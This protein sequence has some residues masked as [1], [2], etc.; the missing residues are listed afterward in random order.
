M[1]FGVVATIQC[2]QSVS[3]EVEGADQDGVFPVSVDY[4]AAV[5]FKFSMISVVFFYD[6]IVALIELH[7]VL[8][9]DFLASLFVKQ[10][11]CKMLWI[12]KAVIPK[13]NCA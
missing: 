5:F 13:L 6:L 12:S 10:C 2:G 11:R 1:C 4:A 9:S 8:F 3:R 7:Q